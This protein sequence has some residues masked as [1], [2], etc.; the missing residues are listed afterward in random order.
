MVSKLR[1]SLTETITTNDPIRCGLG[2]TGLIVSIKLQ[3]EPAFRLHE[4]KVPISFDELIAA[5]AYTDEPSTTDDEEMT[6]GLIDDIARSAEHVRLWWYP[7]TR[8][9]VVSRMNRTQDVS[10]CCW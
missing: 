6:G 2:M 8:G 9:V 3:V 10:C 4:T 5:P 7:Q 1:S